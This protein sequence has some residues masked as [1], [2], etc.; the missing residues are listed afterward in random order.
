MSKNNFLEHSVQTLSEKLSQVEKRLEQVESEQ[1]FSKVMRAN[2]LRMVDV[3]EQ[4]S[5]KQNL[6]ILNFRI[7]KSENDNS[8]RNRL[9]NEFAKLGIDFNQRDIDRAHRTGR[10]RFDEN[11]NISS[12]IIVRFTSW[13]ARNSVYEK[14]SVLPFKV[15]AD[16]TSRREELLSFARHELD[17]PDSLA[18]H[19]IEAVFPDRN[20]KIGLKTKDRRTFTFNTKEE[21]FRILNFIHDS[22]PPYD[23]IWK[24]LEYHKSDIGSNIVNLKGWDVPLWQKSCENNVT[25]ILTDRKNK[26]KAG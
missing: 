4:Y 26:E 16:L 20:C 6:I 19:L 10:P 1:A 15:K 7:K 12:S 17:T 9:L 8:I 21:F 5:R 14:R 22:Q 23:A 11:G 2:L 13:Y 24:A 18:K 3:N 25:F